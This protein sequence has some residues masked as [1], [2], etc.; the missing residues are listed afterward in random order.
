MSVTKH[1]TDKNLRK[2]LEK[3]LEENSEL[4]PNGIDIKQLM[5]QSLAFEGAIEH[6]KELMESGDFDM[7]SYEAGL[8]AGSMVA[9]SWVAFQTLRLAQMLVEDKGL[10]FHRQLQKNPDH[11]VSDQD[12][13]EV[14]EMVA[15]LTMGKR[16]AEVLIDAFEDADSVTESFKKT[17][18]MIVG[19]NRD[20]PTQLKLKETLEDNDAFMGNFTASVAL[21]R[22]AIY[23]KL[24]IKDE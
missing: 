24:G 5:K 15:G 6:T 19:K 22:T 7:Q 23:K 9:A 1:V 13:F 4:T 11:V 8:H 3:L 16:L 14:I 18:D 10:K 17:V 12:V 20:C 2:Q 21:Q